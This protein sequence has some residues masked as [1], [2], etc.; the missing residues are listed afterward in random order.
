MF[1]NFYKGLNVRVTHCTNFPFLCRHWAKEGWASSLIKG[2]EYTAV[3]W[4]YPLMSFSL[5]VDLKIQ[6][7]VLQNY[8]FSSEKKQHT[9]SLS[10][11]HTHTPTYTVL[12]IKRQLSFSL[13]YFCSVRSIKISNMMIFNEWS[14]STKQPVI[15]KVQHND[16]DCKCAGLLMLYCRHK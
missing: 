4:C 16:T 1:V 12:G 6:V 7:C 13:F 14:L 15:M 9:H 3:F 8:W 10:L 11:F 2:F 5:F